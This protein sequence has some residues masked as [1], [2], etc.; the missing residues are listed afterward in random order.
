LGSEALFGFIGVVL[1]SLTT[2]ALTIYQ[3][4][5]TGKREISIRDQQYEHDRKSSR[6]VFQRESILTLQSAV[7][8]MIQASYDEVDRILAELQQTGEWRARQWETPTAIGW[9][10]AVLKL[11]SSRARVFDD[12]LRSLAT[13]LR[14]V[15][16]DSVW[17]QNLE[18]AKQ[19]GR[20]LEPLQ[21]RFHEAVTRVLPTLY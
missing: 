5:V 15:A 7:M 4:R 12:E 17:A 11:E 2:S 20:Q 14:T 1:G 19:A 8:D 10:A 16:G 21:R 3:E 18:S 9:S 13:E 6:D